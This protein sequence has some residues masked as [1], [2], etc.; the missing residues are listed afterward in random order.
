MKLIYEKGQ[1]PVAQLALDR[2]MPSGG[3]NI[4]VVRIQNGAVC[5]YKDAPMTTARHAALFVLT[6]MERL[7]IGSKACGGSSS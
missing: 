6:D 2:K 4:V 1:Y 5:G 3:S 7:V